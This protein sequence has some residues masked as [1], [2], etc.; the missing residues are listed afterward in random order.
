MANKSL[1]N[2]INDNLKY[3][4]NSMLN[5]KELFAMDKPIPG[6]TRFNSL[7]NMF[8]KK[9]KDATMFLEETTKRAYSGPMKPLT[10][11]FK[12]KELYME[13]STSF[14]ESALQIAKTMNQYFDSS[15]EGEDNLY[16]VLK[17]PEFFTII[18]QGIIVAYTELELYLQYTRKN[19]QEFRKTNAAYKSYFSTFDASDFFYRYNNL[20]AHEANITPNSYNVDEFD[21][22][23]SVI[24]LILCTYNRYFRETNLFEPSTEINKDDIE[25][26]VRQMTN[27]CT[28][29]VV[30]VAKP[31]KS[32]SLKYL[33]NTAPALMGF[34]EGSDNNR[35]IT[36]LGLIQ[37]IVGDKSLYQTGSI[38]DIR[39]YLDEGLKSNLWGFGPNDRLTFETLQKGDSE[40]DYNKLQEL[41]YD[42]FNK[43]LNDFL[44]SYSQFI[45]EKKK[46]QRSPEDL[47]EDELKILRSMASILNSLINELNQYD[48]HIQK[49]FADETSKDSGIPTETID[50]FLSMCQNCTIFVNSVLANTPKICGM[51]DRYTKLLNIALSYKAELDKEIAFN[52]QTYEITQTLVNTLTNATLQ[53]TS[54]NCI[55]CYDEFLFLNSKKTLD[56]FNLNLPVFINDL[57]DKNLYF[58]H[59][60]FNFTPPD[61]YFADE[62]I[63]ADNDF[64][65]KLIRDAS[66]KI[67]DIYNYLQ[68]EFETLE[69]CNTAT[70][71][72]ELFANTNTNI[73]HTL[74]TKKYIEEAQKNKLTSLFSNYL[75]LDNTIEAGIVADNVGGSFE[76]CFSL[77]AQSVK[78]SAFPLVFSFSH[79]FFAMILVLTQDLAD[80]NTWLDALCTNYLPKKY[81]YWNFIVKMIGFYCLRFGKMDK[82]DVLSGELQ[83]KI[84]FSNAV[85]Q[86]IDVN[87]EEP[88]STTQVNCYMF[89]E[90]IKNK[91]KCKLI[92]GPPTQ[93]SLELIVNDARTSKLTPQ[94]LAKLNALKIDSNDTKKSFEELNKVI[95]TLLTTTELGEE[96]VKEMDLDFNIGDK[97]KLT[98]IIAISSYMPFLNYNQNCF[99][100]SEKNKLFLPIKYLIK[101]NPPG[102]NNQGILKSILFVV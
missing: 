91:L 54:I 57:L 95:P 36:E 16:V 46:T 28:P 102:P 8:D 64:G 59:S 30:A 48:K 13:F 44:N 21:N 26:F 73:K 61:L 20:L 11:Y 87:Y 101:K 47:N 15:K 53:R 98:D 69:V 100:F 80:V 4:K 31:P 56:R 70:N 43:K 3:L 81:Y 86:W 9:N 82:F 94:N 65:N 29:S 10:D 79:E 77:N 58:S 40:L 63:E 84:T 88:D 66:K 33:K 14:F 45:N 92:G 22:V 24:K 38:N 72:N 25:K 62:T 6:T 55:V 7:K 76:S 12:D 41:K 39:K 2:Q 49:Y 74:I 78:K 71:I 96:F 85:K 27:F 51:V 1:L 68:N 35:T 17:Q 18:V 60:I 97:L 93:P 32:L 90:F 23:F 83:M 37:S 89:N 19:L 50:D 42:S 5:I 99:F 67:I 75:T 52:I 34:L